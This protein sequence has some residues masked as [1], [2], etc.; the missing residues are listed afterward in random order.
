LSLK[1][2]KNSY[3]RKVCCC[4]KSGQSNVPVLLLIQYGDVPLSEGQFL[5]Y[6]LFLSLPHSEQLKAIMQH[7]VV[8]KQ[9]DLRH[10]LSLPAVLH[11]CLKGFQ[12]LATAQNYNIKVQQQVSLC[13]QLC[14]VCYTLPLLTL[15]CSVDV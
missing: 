13:I 14:T 7:F 11:V 9:P 1:A 6:C 10:I 3:S 8:P 12:S 2:T 5:N 15:L 4:V